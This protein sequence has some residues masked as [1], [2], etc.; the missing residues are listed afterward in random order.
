MQR[1]NLTELNQIYINYQ[2]DAAFIDAL[3]E[4][5]LIEVV[6]ISETIYIEDNQLVLLEKYIHF[7][8]SL[9]INLAGIETISQLL[10]NIERLNEE[11]TRLNNKLQFYEST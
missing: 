8:H 9:D 1:N 10:L 5:G 3:K 6:D 4:T 11:L 7:Y 2:V